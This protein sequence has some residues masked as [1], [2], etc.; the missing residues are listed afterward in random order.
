MIRGAGVYEI[1]H[2]RKVPNRPGLLVVLSGFS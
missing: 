1:L 2:K